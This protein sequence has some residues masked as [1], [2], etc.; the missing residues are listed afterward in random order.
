MIFINLKLESASDAQKYVG[1]SLNPL[2][3][4]KILVFQELV[5]EGEEAINFFFGIVEMWG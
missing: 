5:E 4:Q 1:L 3:T 2:T